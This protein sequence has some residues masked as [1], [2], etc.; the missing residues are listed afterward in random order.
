MPKKIPILFSAL[1]V[2]QIQ[3]G[4]KDRTRR[5]VKGE[6]L[7]WLQDGFTPEFVASTENNLCP[8]GDIGDILWIREEHYCWGHWVKDGRTKLDRQKW[9]FVPDG[10]EGEVL[11]SDNKPS[12][13]RISRSKTDPGGNSWHKRLGR[14]MPMKYCRLFLEVTGKRIEHLHDITEED[15]KR[16]GVP[17]KCYQDEHGVFHVC[18]KNSEDLVGSFG[19]YK[20][21]FNALWVHINGAESWNANGW[22]WVMSFK[23]KKKV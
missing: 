10:K 7:K 15:A 17:Q 2:Q 14:F 12:S 20:I 4:N 21:G 3:S 16:E 18:E 19:S 22:V 6:A 1:M 23:L 9:K 5:G 11:F 8:Y 13:F